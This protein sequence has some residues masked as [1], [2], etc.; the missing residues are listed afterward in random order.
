MLADHAAL[1]GF[2]SALHRLLT[3]SCFLS[4]WFLAPDRGGPTVDPE[5]DSFVWR[6][7]HAVAV[8]LVLGFSPFSLRSIL[9]PSL[10][11][12]LLVLLASP[13]T[14]THHHLRVVTASG[15]LTLI[16]AI[17][18]AVLVKLLRMALARCE[19][20]LRASPLGPV[21]ARERG[22]IHAPP[23]TK[24]GTTVA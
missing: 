16:L 18:P 5:S 14:E 11:F 12:L 17:P 19:L 6:G 3:R 1:H 21:A 9:D 20:S 2:C 15:L 4:H 10:L 22:E 7:I 24:N 13:C 8:A 23:F